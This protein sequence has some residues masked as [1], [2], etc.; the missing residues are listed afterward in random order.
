M[1]V[2]NTHIENSFKLRLRL[3]PKTKTGYLD[4]KDQIMRSFTVQTV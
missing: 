3:L 2:R 4:N 1:S